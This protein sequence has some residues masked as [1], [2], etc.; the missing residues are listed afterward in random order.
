MFFSNPY[1]VFLEISIVPTDRDP[2]NKGF[3]SPIFS[4]N[5]DE[6]ML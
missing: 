3:Q 1:S 5:I 6:L 4:T 2:I